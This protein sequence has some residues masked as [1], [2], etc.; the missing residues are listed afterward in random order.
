MIVIAVL[1]NIIQYQL[2][3]QVYSHPFFIKLLKIMVYFLNLKIKIHGNIDNV[4]KK[5]VLVMCNHYDGVDFFAISHIYGYNKL[6]TIVKH[7]LVGSSYHKNLLSDIFYYL[8][9]S[10]YYSSYFVPYK[11]GDKDDGNI[12][13]EIIIDKLTKDNILIFPEGRSRTDGVPKDF[14]HGIF[15]LAV[16]H[17]LNILPISIK[18]DK[19]AG[20]ETNGQKNLFKWFDLT[21]DIYIHDI[22]SCENNDYLQLKDDILKTITDVLVETPK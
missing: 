16:D 1:I 21:A 4:N 22:V 6:Y 9:N 3:P 13:K 20:T 7:D 15:K 8:K 2:L 14:K 10:F 19:D 18:Y 11:R 12:I 17:H 5:Q